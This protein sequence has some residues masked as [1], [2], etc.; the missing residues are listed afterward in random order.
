MLDRIREIESDGRAVRVDILRY[1]MSP[2]EART[3][4]AAVH[5]A[6]GLTGK[7][8]GGS[9]RQPAV[10][11]NSSL[12]KPAKFK[13]AHQVVLLRVG[14]T[15]SDPSYEAVRH[16][17]RIGRRWTDPDS[18]RSPQWAVIVTGDLVAA[19]YR[20]GEWEA[21]PAP[22]D[23]GRPGRTVAALSDRHSFSGWRDAELEG[24]YV[25]R[26]VAGYLGGITQSPVSYVWCG[27]HWVNTA[28]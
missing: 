7:L 25:G 11:L 10:E 27:P 5:D 18:P 20:I 9:Q 16:G 17:W 1:G 12:A 4:E 24:R 28:G 3:V 26:S 8:A 2:E 19:V 13:R 22:A 14:G 6:L 23:P 21:D 15:G